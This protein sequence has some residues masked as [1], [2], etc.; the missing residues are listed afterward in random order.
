MT[1]S[2]RVHTEFKAGEPTKLDLGGTG[3]AVVGKLVPPP[4]FKDRVFW[5]FALITARVDLVAPPRPPYPAEIQ[6]KP[7]EHQA[8]WNA[9]KQ[10][11]EGQAWVAAYQAF[12]RE[13]SMSPYIT[14]S[15]DRDG[16]FRIDDVPPGDYVMSIR[17]DERSPGSLSNYK[18]HVPPVAGARS[19]D[20]VDLGTITLQ[21]R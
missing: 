13:R 3:R 8:W 9:W 20:E 19:D 17:F 16:S 14:A 11:P 18:L 10:T 21:P 7:Q 1:S 15:V 12:E 6:N 4:G 5:N 2:V